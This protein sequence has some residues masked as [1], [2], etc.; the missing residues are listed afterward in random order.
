MPEAK[1]FASLSSTLLARK[2]AAR[3]AMRPQMPMTA[4]EQQRLLDGAM[5]DGGAAQDDLGWNDMGFD[6]ILSGPVSPIRADVTPLTDPAQPEVLR[7]IEALVEKINGP[8]AAVPAAPVED[9]APRPSRRK[10]TALTQ[11]RKAAFT[12]RL[13]EQ[14]HLRL[15][16]ASAM[17]DRSAQALVVDALDRLLDAMLGRDDDAR[18]TA[19]A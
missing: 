15:R 11:G 9:I 6:A 10:G 5:R 2:G 19:E 13:D 4:E 16:L 8:A 3:P 7:R 1:P 12:L 18:K 17:V 14:R